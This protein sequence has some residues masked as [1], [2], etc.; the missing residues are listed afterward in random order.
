MV[1]SSIAMGTE[2]A[3]SSRSSGCLLIGVVSSSAQTLGATTGALN[4]KVTDVSGA[5]LSGV[6]VVATSPAMMRARTI[7]T[8]ARGQYEVPAVPPGEYTLAFSLPPEFKQ[9]IREGILVSLGGT[10]TVDE[11][12]VLAAREETVLVAGE[13]PVLDRSRTAIVFSFE[14]RQ[15]ADLPASR[16][17]SA[18]LDA[19]PG[20]QLTR[21]D[22]GGSAGPAGGPYSAYGTSGLNRPTIEGIAISSYNPLG[23]TLD[24]GSFEHVAV[25]LGAHGPAWPWPGVAIQFIT[26]SGGNRHAGSLYLDYE[27]RGW[28]SFNID[29]GSDSAR[30]AERGPGFPHEEAN[31]LWR[32]RDANVG[33]GGPLK[34]DRLWWYLSLRTQQ[35]AARQ[36]SFPVKPVQAHITNLGGKGTA[37]YGHKRFSGSVRRRGIISRRGSTAFFDRWRQSI[38]SEES[39]SNQIAQGGVWK[40]EWNAI[41]SQRF[42][43]ELLGGQ[44]IAGRHERPNGTSPRIRGHQSGRVRRQSQLGDQRIATTRSSR[45]RRT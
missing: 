32:Y 34:Q 37:S 24:Y 45:L 43:F 42:Y 5:P 28:Q 27:H 26:K 3:W 39:T 30:R 25:G 16:S 17:S 38:H 2:A 18:I 36:V 22:V 7:V 11:V 8:D 44:F 23:F 9:M 40:V 19:T 4:G 41:V 1:R 20:V 14:A 15:L 29:D 31:R 21:F 35:T 6:T 12:L 10:T 13:S 33:V